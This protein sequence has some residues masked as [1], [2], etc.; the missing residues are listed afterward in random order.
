MSVFNIPLEVI[1]FAVFPLLTL[2]DLSNLA[3]VCTE[4]RRY[5]LKKYAKKLCDG[6]VTPEL[7]KESHMSPFELLDMWNR[8]QLRLSCGL[9][10]GAMIAWDGLLHVWEDGERR[11]VAQGL[12]PSVRARS[13]SCGH[14]HTVVV[15]S[16][17]Q[18]YALGSNEHG[19]LGTGDTALRTNLTRM[20]VDEPV[21]AAVGGKEFTLILT[22]SNKLLWCG[23]LEVDGVNEENEANVG[24]VLTP[25]E[26]PFR[27]RLQP[28][29]IITKICAGAQHVLVLT[30]HNRLFSAG[31]VEHWQ[32]GRVLT[33]NEPARELHQVRFPSNL[34]MSTIVQ[35]AAGV[36]HS[37]VLLGDGSVYSFG[38]SSSGELG[39]PRFESSIMPRVIPNLP[40]A[41]AIS[42]GH[43]H[44]LI[45]AAQQNKIVAFGMASLG[46][47]GYRSSFWS[48]SSPRDCPLPQTQNQRIK[49]I[50]AGSTFS[51]CLSGSG[52]DLYACGKSSLCAGAGYGTKAQGVLTLFSPVPEVG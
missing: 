12:P 5:L 11:T 32:L 22:T 14:S 46:Q 38:T 47:L 45:L 25:R 34:A 27:D 7:V 44:S 31:N 26:I 42:A 2:Q 24:Q 1:E 39:L 6:V 43:Q 3:A 36:A 4:W 35:I 21:E 49:Y 51:V 40:K 20:L 48:S 50:G 15:G 29:E 17:N 8:G 9:N 30:N 23:S 16:D 19:E 18:V 13:V 52:Q 37:L 33:E 10:H 28:K 41:I